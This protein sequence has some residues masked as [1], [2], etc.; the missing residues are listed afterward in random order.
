MRLAVKKP[1]IALVYDW[2]DTEYGG[3]EKLLLALGKI[4]PEAPLYTSIY[5][6]AA[7]HWT[8]RFKVVPSWVNKLP[9]VSRHEL[10]APL[11]PVAFESFDFRNF[12]LVI[13]VSSAFAKGIITAPSTLHVCYCLTPTRFLWHEAQSYVSFNITNLGLKPL[14]SYLRTWDLTAAA[15]PDIYVATSNAIAQKI[16]KLYHQ[17][18]QKIIFPP[19]ET[20]VFTPPVKPTPAADRDYFLLVSRLVP[21]KHVELAIKAFNQLKYPLVIV[22]TGSESKKLKRIAGSN[23]RFEGNLPREKLISAYR[24]AKSLIIPQEEDFGLVGL[25]ANACGTS[26]IAYGAGGYRETIAD[27]ISGSFFSPQT[28]DALVGVVSNTDFS[29]YTP[30]NCRRNTLRFSFPLFRRSWLEFLSGHAVFP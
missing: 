19:I 6:P 12:D 20:D 2:L 28:P 4:F 9:F 1:K 3:A 25:E 8:S 17:N 23:I 30:A 13:S 24:G 27:G 29:K 14:F 5:K 21:Y 7:Y 18:V 26:V 22:G 15:R 10:V 16:Q 11:L